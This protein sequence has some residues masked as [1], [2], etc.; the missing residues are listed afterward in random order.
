M[1]YYV[2]VFIACL[3][4]LLFIEPGR[5]ILIFHHLDSSIINICSFEMSVQ[6]STVE[7]IV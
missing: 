7:L 4:T 3:A 1:F 6:M 2:Y 5:I